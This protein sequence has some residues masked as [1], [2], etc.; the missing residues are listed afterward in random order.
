MQSDELIRE[1]IERVAGDVGLIIYTLRPKRE[2]TDEELSAELGI[3]INDVRKS[4]FALYELGLAEYRRKRDDETGWME[5]Y[6]KI[7]YDKQNEVLRRELL[8]T[9]RKL[10]EKLEMEEASVYYICVNGCIKVNYEE[11]MEFNFMCPRCGGF[12]EYFDT[13]LIVEKVREEIEKI[14]EMLSNLQ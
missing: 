6:W 1:L 13:S 4:L 5:Y 9:R 7:N 12:L 11:A 14:D 10:E 2:F 8:K 3:E